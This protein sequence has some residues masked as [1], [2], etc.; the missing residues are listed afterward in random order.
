LV[1]RFWP[2]PAGTKLKLQRGEET[3]TESATTL[4][5]VAETKL[6]SDL[7]AQLILSLNLDKLVR[8]PK[9]AKLELP[10]DKKRFEKKDTLTCQDAHSTPDEAH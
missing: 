10:L 9:G 2:V 6:G 4:G 8:V 1:P 7:K 5:K 3:T